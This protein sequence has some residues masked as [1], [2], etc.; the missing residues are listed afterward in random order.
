M[1]NGV[2][3][4]QFITTLYEN[5]HLL[6]TIYRIGIEQNGESEQSPPHAKL[7]AMPRILS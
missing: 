1:T 6:E 5:D 2:K 3:Y 4:E 7:E